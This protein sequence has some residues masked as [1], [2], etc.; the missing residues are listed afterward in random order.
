[1]LGPELQSPAMKT[2]FSRYDDAQG[3]DVPLTEW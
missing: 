3:F 2:G 1:M